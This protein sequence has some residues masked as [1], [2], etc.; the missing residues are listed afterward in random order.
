VLTALCSV[1]GPRKLCAVWPNPL[2]QVECVGPLRVWFV[3]T[4]GT[5]PEA[6]FHSPG[7]E[8]S[9]V[10][11]KAAKR[12]C[13]SIGVVRIDAGPDHAPPAITAQS[14]VPSS[15][16]R[17]LRPIFYFLFPLFSQFGVFFRFRCVL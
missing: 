10:G 13:R 1:I 8:G 2:V 17:V 15:H 5:Y 9:G 14:S 11:N 4:D 12:V 7:R 3:G 6:R 16:F